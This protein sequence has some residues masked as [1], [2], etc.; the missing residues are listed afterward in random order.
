M[1]KRTADEIAA[2]LLLDNNQRGL[3]RLAAQVERLLKIRMG[4]LCPYCDSTN[5]VS[6]DE[7]GHCDDCDTTWGLDDEDFD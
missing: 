6:N 5:V 1:R 3:E 2:E 4:E 7:L